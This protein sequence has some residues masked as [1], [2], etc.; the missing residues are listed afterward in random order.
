MVRVASIAAL[1]LVVAACADTGQERLLREHK[2]D[3]VLLFERGSYG[4]ARETFEAALALQPADPNLLFNLGRCHEML[5]QTTLAE[6][7]YR[8]CLAVAPD[9]PECRHA[10][11]VLLVNQGRRQE[12]VGL[13]D[14]WL[15]ARPDTS[16]PYAEDGWLWHQA[17]DLPRA[18]GRLQQALERDPRD[19]RALTELALVYEDMHRPDRAATLYERALTYRPGQSD[20]QARL[21]RLRAAGTESPRPD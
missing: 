13:V 11:T 20:V 14:D 5:R 10:L 8:A 6:Q 4:P 15:R 3:G 21:T 16:S 2:Q 9:H 7:R 19:N 12:A 17:G 1:L 18:Q